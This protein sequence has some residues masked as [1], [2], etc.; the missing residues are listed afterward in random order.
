LRHAARRPLPPPSVP[1][2]LIAG[3]LPARVT[4]HKN[5]RLPLNDGFVVAGGFDRSVV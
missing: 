3:R 2:E 5:G 1:R 4:T